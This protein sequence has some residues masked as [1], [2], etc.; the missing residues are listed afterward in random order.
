MIS[1]WEHQIL[2]K[3]YTVEGSVEF[4]VLFKKTAGGD[5]KVEA[6]AGEGLGRAGL[7]RIMCGSKIRHVTE[8]LPH[9]LIVINTHKGGWELRGRERESSDWIVVGKTRMG[10]RHW[11]A[12][13][14]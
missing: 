8:F 3:E 4:Y 1:S 12:A 9:M 7:L 10:S 2:I 14:H 6:T 5:N 13:V 11:K